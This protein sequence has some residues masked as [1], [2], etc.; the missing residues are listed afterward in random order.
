MASPIAIEDEVVSDQ[1]VSEEEQSKRKGRM[2]PEDF[3]PKDYHVIIGA[4]NTTS[5]RV[6]LYY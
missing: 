3:A 4:L 2:L 5:S 1:R 6:A